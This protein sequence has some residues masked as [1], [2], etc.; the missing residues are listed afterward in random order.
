MLSLI[1]IFEF[2]ARFAGFY[3]AASTIRLQLV[4]QKRCAPTPSVRPMPLKRSC[5][6]VGDWVRKGGWQHWA[7]SRASRALGDRAVFLLTNPL[8]HVP[9]PQ[10]Y[11]P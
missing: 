8:L 7:A 2:L 3:F 5:K 1:I 9:A 10:G 4:L 6:P 11:R